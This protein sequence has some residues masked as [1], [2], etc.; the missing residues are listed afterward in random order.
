MKGAAH[1]YPDEGIDTY[2]AEEWATDTVTAAA[3]GAGT[4]D[5]EV[6]AARRF[7]DRKNSALG[8]DT[9]TQLR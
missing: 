6:H 2:V 9:A 5:Y 8:V 4:D 7:L 1:N 3:A